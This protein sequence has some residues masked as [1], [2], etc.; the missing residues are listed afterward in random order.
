[1]KFEFM[2]TGAA[3]I[4]IGGIASAQTTTYSQGA[5]TTAIPLSVTPSP[6]HTLSKLKTPK[7]AD[8]RSESYE[9]FKIAHANGSTS[10]G[11]ATIAM[12]SSW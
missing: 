7:V 8:N 9:A 10:Q 4:K 2:R 6:S 3:L 5:T 11:V 1:M 12:V